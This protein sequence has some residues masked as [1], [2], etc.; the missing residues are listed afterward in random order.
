M[1]GGQL[2]D[3]QIDSG[4]DGERPSSSSDTS[5]SR[6]SS[7]SETSSASEDGA[8]ADEWEGCDIPDEWRPLPL[9]RISGVPR[10]ATVP[11]LRWVLEAEGYQVRSVNFDPRSESANGLA[12]FV[13]LAPPH[14]STKNDDLDVEQ[15]VVQV[16]HNAVS[17]L[18]RKD[19][20]PTLHG[21]KLH[22]ER[23]TAEA[24][25]FSLP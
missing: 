25:L 13:R 11:E 8:L 16:A 3:E 15:D 17:V 5:R 24:R 20:S 22:F 10:D 1:E 14:P 9:L 6:R 2:K 7:R 19:P 18:R 23:P 12:A 21:Q 4:E